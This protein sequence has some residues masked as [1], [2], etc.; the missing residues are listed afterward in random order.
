M[1]IP[2]PTTGPI[3]DSAVYVSWI[4]RKG[5]NYVPREPGITTDELA[6]TILADWL[7]EKWPQIVNHMKAQ[8]EAD[9]AFKESLR[10][11][12]F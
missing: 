4:T 1:D 3:R 2:H 7:K 8:S 12:P 10:P 11:K 5:L 9:K 6:E